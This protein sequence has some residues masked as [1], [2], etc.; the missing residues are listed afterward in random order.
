MQRSGAFAPSSCVGVCVH[1]WGCWAGTLF[2]GQAERSQD[3]GPSQG[4][5]SCSLLHRPPAET[6]RGQLR[7]RLTL[8]PRN[9]PNFTA[10][11]EGIEQQVAAGEASPAGPLSRN[12]RPLRPTSSDRRVLDARCSRPRG[13]TC[14]YHRPPVRWPRMTPLSRTLSAVQGAGGGRAW[15]CI[16]QTFALGCDS[17]P[18]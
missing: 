7:T 8:A 6:P 17:E 2:T 15:G 1:V 13:A 5:G 14:P 4:R 10:K 12:R 18:P 11:L 3:T 9:L 16:S